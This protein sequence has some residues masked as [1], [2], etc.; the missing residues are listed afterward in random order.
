MKSNDQVVLFDGLCN[1]CNGLVIFI[2][3]RDTKSKFK[4][5]ALQ[6]QPGQTLLRKFG[7]SENDINTL[8]YIKG[9]KYFLKSSA[10]L[11]LLKDLGGFWKIFFVFIIIP[12][13]IRNI[14]YNLIAKT[15]YRILGKRETCMVPYPELQNKFLL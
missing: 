4:F 5:A 10:V 9:E 2:I 1:L 12:K 7:L 13:F 6:S 14:F 11:Y 3:K 8:V 15:R